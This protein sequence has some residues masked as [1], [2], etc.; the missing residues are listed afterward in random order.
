[1]EKKLFI[2]KYVCATLA[3]ITP[4]LL[5]L[6]YLK[7]GSASVSGYGSLGY[8][9]GY[10]IVIYLIISVIAGALVLPTWKNY[11]VNIVSGGLMTL[12]GAMFVALPFMIGF[13]YGPGYGSIIIC[14]LNLLAGLLLG[15]SSIYA[16][17]ND[18]ST[19]EVKVKKQ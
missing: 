6:E 5:F 4:F 19:Y 2:I 16:V 8:E 15:L 18:L 1:M 17:V 13:H 12:S 10:R 14:I 7:A 3:L 9:G 11:I